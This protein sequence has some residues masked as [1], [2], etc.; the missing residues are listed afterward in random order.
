MIVSTNTTYYVTDNTLNR[1]YILNDQ[2]VYIGNKSFYY[3]MYISTIDNYLYITGKQNIWKTDKDLNVLIQYN[4]SS[5][6][7]YGICY[8]TAKNLIYAVANYQKSIHIFDLY[9]NPV[10]SISTL[11][12]FPVS[13]AAFRNQ[14]YVNTCHFEQS[15]S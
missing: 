12:Y 8:N 4:N 7:Y 10:D 1:I 9:L 11:T 13:I 6:G 14:V 3:P 2:W 5:A 15:N